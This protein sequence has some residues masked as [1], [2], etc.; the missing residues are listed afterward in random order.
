MLGLVGVIS[1]SA[2]AN[3]QQAERLRRF[4]P[5]LQ[6]LELQEDQHSGL[7]AFWH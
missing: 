4:A 3:V 6:V 5:N 1:W 2:N 7:C